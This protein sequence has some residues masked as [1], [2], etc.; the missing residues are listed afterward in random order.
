MI[1]PQ[2]LV[3]TCEPPAAIADFW[4]QMTEAAPDLFNL[5]FV[6]APGNGRDD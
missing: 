1:P 3:V 4:A 6:L 5:A 2:Q